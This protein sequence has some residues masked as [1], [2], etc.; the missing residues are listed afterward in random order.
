MNLKV[1][2]IIVHQR[3][4]ASHLPLID[5]GTCGLHTVHR[6]LKIGLVSSGFKIEYILKWIW[7]LLKDTSAGRKGYEKVAKAHY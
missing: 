7:N 3:A 6:S 4:E 2:K 1:F 5:I